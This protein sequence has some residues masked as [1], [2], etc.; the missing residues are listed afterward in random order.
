[1]ARGCT[2][3]S[4]AR[5]IWYPV[6][7]PRLRPWDPAIFSAR[8][9]P[10]TT[11]TGFRTGTART[12]LDPNNASSRWL[13]NAAYTIPGDFEFGNAANFYNDVRNPPFF[14]ENFS[15]VKRTPLRETVNIEYRVDMNNL[16]NRTLFGNINTTLGD[17]N[18]GRPTGPMIAP[19][20]IQMAL[21][22]NF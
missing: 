7:K 13:N 5:S 22:L 1:M 9:R 4:R 3:S 12:D 15:I 11:G 18:F 14:S 8:R 19:R 16:F 20:A 10:N 6:R 17:V 2:S 21:K